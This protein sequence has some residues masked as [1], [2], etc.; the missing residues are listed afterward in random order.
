MWYQIVSAQNPH[1]KGAQKPPEITWM[2][3]G[4]E[5]AGITVGI[6]VAEIFIRI[7]DRLWHAL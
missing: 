3:F 4:F 7:A 5:V 2:H 6:L 1:K